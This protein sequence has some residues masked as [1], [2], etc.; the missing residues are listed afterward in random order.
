MLKIAIVG[1]GVAGSFL[2]ALLTQ[3]TK[4]HVDI[5][6]TKPIRGMGCA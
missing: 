6:D 1:A 4:H 2:Y 5:Y 3:N